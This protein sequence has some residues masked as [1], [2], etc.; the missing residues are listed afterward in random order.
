MID[1]LRQGVKMAS[2]LNLAVT[3]HTQSVPFALGPYRVDLSSTRLLRDDVE[4]DLRPQAVQALGTLLRH[5]GGYV[6]YE[7]MIHE[8]WHGVWVSRHT[9]A[10]TIGEVKR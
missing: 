6:D 4:M 10:V 1:S 3:S 9:V 8:A 2:T 5:A 7:R